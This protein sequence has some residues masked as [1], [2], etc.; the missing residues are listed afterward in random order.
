M[1]DSLGAVRLQW[2]WEPE[3][4]EAVGEA[5]TNCTG[6]YISTSYKVA[7][8]R[9]YLLSGGRKVCKGRLMG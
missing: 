8:V 2:A 4:A 1:L 9:R 7:L 3:A 5:Q 6:K